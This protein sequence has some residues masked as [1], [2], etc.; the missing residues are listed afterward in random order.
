MHFDKKINSIKNIILLTQLGFIMILPIAGMLSTHKPSL[1]DHLSLFLLILLSLYIFLGVKENRKSDMVRWWTI[2]IIE[3][4]LVS[5]AIIHYGTL[6]TNLFSIFFIIIAQMAFVLSSVAAIL[7]GV[8]ISISYAISSYLHDPHIFTFNHWIINVFY[9]I[10]I[11]APIIF[12]VKLER[13][14]RDQSEQKEQLI[15]EVNEAN[16][17]LTEYAFHIQE[18]VVTDSLTRLYNQTHAHERFMIEVEIARKNNTELCIAFIDVDN[19]K[20][21][22]DTYGHQFGDDVLR[23]IGSTIVNSVMGTNYVA[24]RYGG[25]EMI[26]IMPNTSLQKAHNFS[27]FIREEI[28]NVRFK[29]LSDLSVTVS[30]GIAA[31]PEDAGN[32]E[33]LTKIA[34]MYMYEAK[35]TGKNKVVSSINANNKDSER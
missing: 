11:S 26:I 15:R 2:F 21:I 34:D 14:Y 28:S 8:L 13:E 27:K 25:E 19:F 4:V 18:L 32:K 7:G 29:S 30:I 6:E 3:I 17:Q 33:T 24:A 16:R 5:I 10:G 22:N 31:F 35:K 1:T 9:L 23:S 20:Q 12:F